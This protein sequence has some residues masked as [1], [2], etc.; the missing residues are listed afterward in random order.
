MSIVKIEHLQHAYLDKVLYDD[1][2]FQVNDQEHVGVIGQNGV[3]KST[4]IKILTKQLVPVNG[5]V[6]W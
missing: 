6:S 4:L 1:T 5:M 2:N 3:G